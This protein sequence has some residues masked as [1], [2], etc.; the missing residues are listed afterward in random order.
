LHLSP[1]YGSISGSDNLVLASSIPVPPQGLIVVNEDPNL[2]PLQFN[3][4]PTRSRAPSSQSPAIGMGNNGAM[5]ASDQRGPGYPRMTGAA[6]SVD[7][8]AVQSDIIFLDGFN[9]PWF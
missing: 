9:V 1:G 3:G 5:R 8:G 6:A 4:G 7:I 2:L